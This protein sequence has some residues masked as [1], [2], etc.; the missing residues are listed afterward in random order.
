MVG[1]EPYNAIAEARMPDPHGLLSVDK[2]PVFMA[3]TPEFA[4]KSADTIVAYLKAWLDVARDFRASDKVANTIYGFYIEGYQLARNIQ[5]STCHDDVGPGF[6]PTSTLH[7]GQAESCSGKDL[8]HPRLGKAL[9]PEFMD[10][11]R[12]GN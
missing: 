10:Q 3:A 7:A 8:L 12:S 5:E 2:I 1:V 9:R 4:A 6:R 11:A